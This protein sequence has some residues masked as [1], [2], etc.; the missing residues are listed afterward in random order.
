M[1][2][3]GEMFS[4][5][6]PPEDLCLYFGDFASSICSVIIV[7]KFLSNPFTATTP[8]TFSSVIWRC[9]C[10]RWKNMHLTPNRVDSRRQPR[11]S[12]SRRNDI[13]GIQ[14][15][16]AITHARYTF[17]AY[18]ISARFNRTSRLKHIRLVN[19]WKPN[20]PVAHTKHVAMLCTSSWTTYLS[21]VPPDL[22]IEC[23]WTSHRMFQ[24]QHNRIK[25]TPTDSLAQEMAECKWL[26]PNE[27]G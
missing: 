15:H 25:H 17:Q 14:Y 3:S 27:S 4:L 13:G 6:S 24:H 7:D 21:S 11:K 2:I 10:E 20:H 19:S 22:R 18:A 12:I 9:T 26:R 23:G 8:P 1:G 16:G 5:A